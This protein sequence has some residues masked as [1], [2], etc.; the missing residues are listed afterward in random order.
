MQNKTLLEKLKLR[1]NDYSTLE[2]QGH[3]AKNNDPTISCSVIIPFHSEAEILEYSL[4]A[5]RSQDLPTDFTRGSVEII[6][7]N[8]GSGIDIEKLVME[9]SK[10]FPVKYLNFKENVGRAVAR[11]AALLH[12]VNDAVIFL[13]ADIVVQEDFLRTHLMWQEVSEN[14]AV[15]GLRENISP[16]A[17]KQ[18]LAYGHLKLTTVPDYRSDFRYRKFV[19]KEWQIEYPD[20]PQE[21]FDR[22]YRILEDTDCFRSFGFYKTVGVWHFIMPLENQTKIHWLVRCKMKHAEKETEAVYSRL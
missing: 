11:N 3:L 15:I 16:G 4:A 14:V 1:N 12:A 9:T 22:E 17:M 21:S 6:L 13:D 19:P 5:L 10:V 2:N 20:L 18:S 7:V 8:D